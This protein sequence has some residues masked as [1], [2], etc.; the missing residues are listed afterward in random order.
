MTL[1]SSINIHCVCN[2]A[3]PA[4]SFSLEEIKSNL[5]IAVNQEYV[6][7]EDTVRLKTGDEVAVIPPISGG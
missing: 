6:G 3:F 7:A 5:L 2:Y 4:V 1:Y